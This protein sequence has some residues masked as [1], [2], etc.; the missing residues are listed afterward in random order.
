MEE[1]EAFDILIDE[2]NLRTEQINKVH[3]FMHTIKEEYKQHRDFIKQNENSTIE[4]SEADKEYLR[5]QLLCSKVRMEELSPV[6]DRAEE[7][8]FNLFNV[9]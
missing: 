9:K 7:E 1:K 2:T 5:K 4:R 6:L 8:Y 3:Y